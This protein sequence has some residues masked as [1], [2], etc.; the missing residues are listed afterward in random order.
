[1]SFALP[2][3][4]RRKE[5]AQ[6]QQLHAQRRHILILGP[7]GIGK[8]ALVA[9]LR[10]SL[11]LLVCPASERLR[12]I[13][14]ALEREL[15]LDAGDFHLVQ[16]KNR[17]LKSLKETE[18]TVVFD[19]AGWTTPKVS[20]F[21]ECVSARGPVWLCCRSAE[22]WNIGH[23]WPLLARFE[24][25]ELRPFH[26]HETRSFVETAVQRRFAPQDALASVG[27]LHR[28]AHGLPQTLCDLLVRLGSHHYNLASTHGLRL[29]ELDRHIQQLSA[30]GRQSGR[31]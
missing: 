1:M 21:L 11:R 20:S 7:E 6:L 18:R 3:V 26:L 10:A 17:L 31:S 29:L 12:E 25:V 13:Y 22:P 5:A 9:H 2:F 30:F 23:I 28:L 16:R 27:Q 8:S 15:G 19:G 24:R 4:G 14:D